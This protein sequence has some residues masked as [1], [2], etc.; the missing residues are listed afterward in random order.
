M[1]GGFRGALLGH[2]S[3]GLLLIPRNSNTIKPNFSMKVKPRL[4]VLQR[5]E[6]NTLGSLCLGRCFLL[7]SGNS[8][9]LHRGSQLHSARLRGN[10]F[11]PEHPAWGWGAEMYCWASI[12]T[13]VPRL[14]LEMFC[15]VTG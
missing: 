3:L 10:R 6:A 5:L 8:K 1:R 14:Q 11:Q 15:D 2:E 9:Y 7:V 12:C 13:H 4:V